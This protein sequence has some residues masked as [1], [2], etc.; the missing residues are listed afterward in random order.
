MFR[1]GKPRV[2]ESAVLALWGFTSTSARTHEHRE[3]TRILHFQSAAPD[4]V[5]VIE[6]DG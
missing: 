4:T 2:K 3:S 6:L 5:E 1:R